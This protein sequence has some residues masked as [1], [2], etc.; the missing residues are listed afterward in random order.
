MFEN[1]NGK[2]DLIS[3]NPPYVPKEE[4]D[5]IQYFKTRYGGNDGTEVMSLFLEQAKNFLLPDGKIILGVNSFYVSKEKCL[6]LFK[7]YR[8]EVKKITKI[9]LNTSIVFVLK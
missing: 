4:N 5:K 3:F 8:Y 6:N 9:F 7:K 1:I 2:F